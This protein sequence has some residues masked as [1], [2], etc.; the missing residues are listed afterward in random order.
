ML[1]PNALPCVQAA[2]SA[3]TVWKL[4]LIQRSV[5]TAT[6][7]IVWTAVPYQT[8]S[9]MRVAVRAVAQPTEL[10]AVAAVISAA[11]VGE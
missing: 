3:K 7:A 8:A 1:A 9:A 2:L 11:N 4:T 5:K 6:V 10:Y